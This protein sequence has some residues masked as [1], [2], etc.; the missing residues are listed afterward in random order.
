MQEFPMK[1]FPLMV[2]SAAIG[3]AL[4]AGVT[5]QLTA[6]PKTAAVVPSGGSCYYSWYTCSYPD[7]TYWTG[8]QPGNSPGMIP[9]SIASVI[10]GTYVPNA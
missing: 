8:C 7:N 4:L 6:E 2:A 9:T 5:H 1:R 10:C 3:L